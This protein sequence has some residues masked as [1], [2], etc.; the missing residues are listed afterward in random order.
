MKHVQRHFYG[1]LITK[2]P[3]FKRPRSKNGKKRI[4]RWNK[5]VLRRK[6]GVGCSDD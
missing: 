3:E 6:A 2:G 5:R 1:P 4:K